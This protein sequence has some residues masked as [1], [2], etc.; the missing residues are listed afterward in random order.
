MKTEQEHEDTIAVLT[1][2]ITKPK[3]TGLSLMREPFPANQIGQL[4]KPTAAQTK[5]RPEEKINCPICGSWHH[6]KVQHL[7]YV[8]H[9]A[10]TD[11]LLDAD[12]LWFWEPLTFDE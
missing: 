9:A 4:P 2:E 5:C 7:D 1:D 12:P 3:L 8:G 6:P 10:L 11:R